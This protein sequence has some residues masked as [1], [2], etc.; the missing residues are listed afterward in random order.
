LRPPHIASAPLHSAPQ[1]YLTM[2]HGICQ[3]PSLRHQTVSSARRKCGWWTDVHMPTWRSMISTMSDDHVYPTWPLLASPLSHVRMHSSQTICGHTRTSVIIKQNNNIWCYYLLQV[4]RD[5]LIVC[6]RN[7]GYVLRH[8]CYES[9]PCLLVAT[10]VGIKIF[11]AGIY[12]GLFKR[13]EDPASVWS[14]DDVDQKG[15]RQLRSFRH[16]MLPHGSLWAS[17]HLHYDVPLYTVRYNYCTM[18][19]MT[20]QMSPILSG[21]SI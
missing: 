9:G 16:R 18:V 19:V 20:P 5:C 15:W 12:Q 3:Y 2:Q 13:L 14:H 6:L 17:R 4:I 1:I 10:V 7:V 11:I 8:S 21:V